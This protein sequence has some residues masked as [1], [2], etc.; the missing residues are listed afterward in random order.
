MYCEWFRGPQHGQYLLGYLG[1]KRSDRECKETRMRTLELCE[2]V[3][4]E[5][6]VAS[7]GQMSE[8]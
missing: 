6:D 2:G 5:V 8:R 3:R 7:A 4:S 1:K